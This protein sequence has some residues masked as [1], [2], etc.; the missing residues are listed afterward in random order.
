MG[1][2]FGRNQKRRMRAEIAA[3][4]EQAHNMRHLLAGERVT[5]GKLRDKFD[6]LK[7]D[8]ETWDAEIKHLLGDFSSFRPGTHGYS[9][10]HPENMAQLRIMPNLGPL[11]TDSGTL[12]DSVTYTIERLLQVVVDSDTTWE[13]RKYLRLRITDAG[14]AEHDMRY[15]ISRVQFDR[16]QLG[17]RERRYVAERIAQE[18]CDGINRGL[19][20]RRI[21]EGGAI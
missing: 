6:R 21:R 15:A 10:P 12:S 3:K 16:A 18:L 17:P 14:Y 7:Q 19:G 8:V 11:V 9:H 20:D 4:E 1:N 5:N 2:R 13:G